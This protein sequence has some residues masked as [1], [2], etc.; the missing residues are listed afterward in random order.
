MD[1]EFDEALIH[2]GYA[3][4]LM[5]QIQD[6]RK[7]A[8]YK[9]DDEIFG[10]WHSDDTELSVAINKWSD[11]IKRDVMLRS[12]ENSPHDDKTYDVEK[13]FDL[14]TGKKIWVGVKK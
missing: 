10:Q 6:M 11:E 5:R 13:E 1:S 12:F 4:E 14:V 8:K 9:V 3:R 7:E 2:E